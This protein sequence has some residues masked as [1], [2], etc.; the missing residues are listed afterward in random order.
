MQE[1]DT[2]MEKMAVKDKEEKG[3]ESLD[4]VIPVKGKK[5][6]WDRGLLACR[7]ALRRS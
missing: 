7:A 1:A 4:H 6:A 3:R 2:Q 5:E